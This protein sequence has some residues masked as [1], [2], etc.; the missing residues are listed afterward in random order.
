MVFS[1]P[2]FF[3]VTMCIPFITDRQDY[4]K[5][6]FLKF[7]YIYHYKTY[8]SISLSAFLSLFKGTSINLIGCDFYP[9]ILKVSPIA[10]FL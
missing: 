10:T 2:L 6:K 1:M 7:R 8:K 3:I 5:L 4:Q 9:L